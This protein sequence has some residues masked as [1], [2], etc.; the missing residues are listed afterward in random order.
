MEIRL[1]LDDEEKQIWNEIKDFY[2]L[3]SNSE[4]VRLMMV[5]FYR[6]I[7]E[8]KEKGNDAFRI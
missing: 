7:K 5:R 1:F 6:H 2:G 4:L 3:K 8:Q